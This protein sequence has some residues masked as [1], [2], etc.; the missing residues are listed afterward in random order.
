MFFFL[1]LV[2]SSCS[3][4]SIAD[5]VTSLSSLIITHDINPYLTEGQPTT[6]TSDMGLP[7]PPLDTETPIEDEKQMKM[8]ENCKLNAE[9]NNTK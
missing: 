7:T 1:L 9:Q 5:A 3:I 6:D 2:D 4:M 8:E